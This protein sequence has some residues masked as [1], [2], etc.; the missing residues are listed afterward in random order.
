M[1]NH[2]IPY[3]ETGYFSELIL[4]YLAQDKSVKFL[5]NRFPGLDHFGEQIQEKAENYNQDNR[6]ILVEAIKSQ[7]KNLKPSEATQKQ[8]KNLKSQT[9]F[10]VTT[11][12]Q[13]NLFTGPLYFLYKIIST[14]NLCKELESKYP[15]NHFVPVY[16]MATEDHDFDEINFFNFK[17]KKVVWE[18]KAGG[19]VGELSTEGLDKVFRSFSKTLGTSPHAEKLKTLFKSAYLSHDNL[20]DATRF[21]AHELFD[22]YGLLILDANDKNLKQLFIP[23]IEREL[24]DKSCST[25]VAKTNDS[26]NTLKGKNYKLQVNPREINLFYLENGSRERIIEKDGTFFINN[27]GKQFSK[28]ALE[29]EVKNHPE[30]FSPNVLMRPL[31]QEVIL[32]N[33]CY[34]GGGGELAYWLQLKSYFSEENVCF[35]ILLLRN[36]ALL[37]TKKQVAKIKN[38]NISLNDLFLPKNELETKITKQIS[39]ISIDFSPQR[40]HLQQQFKNLYILAEQTDVSFRKAVEAQEKKQLNGLDVLE[41]RLLKAQKRKLADHL[42]RITL[43]QNE[44]FP[45]GSLQERTANFSEF[46]LEYGEEIIEILFMRL[47]PLRQEFLCLE[48]QG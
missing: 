22:A 4:D 45:N 9:A 20:A 3:A 7:Y 44:L 41:K 46:Y 19:A 24:F 48:L 23:H 29:T 12:H 25:A 26:I 5:Y 2:C 30:K 16:W 35:P 21:L 13:L 39:T 27:S 6:K 36:S 31:Y 47:K 17:N 8:I 42:Y 40:K 43:L 10:T 37:V 33:L 1:P 38:L 28:K 11:G 34:I 18:R 14:I 15:Q 32:P